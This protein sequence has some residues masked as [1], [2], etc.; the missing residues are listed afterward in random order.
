LDDPNALYAFVQGDAV[1]YIG[2][3]TRGVRKRFVT[4]RRP[5]KEQRTNLRCN[6][7][8][9]EALKAGAE[10]RILVFAPISHLRYLHFE[11]NLAAGL[12]DSLIT[13]FNPPWN[14]RERDKPITEEAEREQAEENTDQAADTIETSALVARP[15]SGPP[16]AS[17]KI[18]LGRAYFEQGLINPGVEAS[19]H[20]GADG[21][22]IQVLFDDGSDPVLSRINRRANPS[23]AVR[24]VGRNRQI[25]E[26]FQRHFRIGDVVGARVIDAN[27]ILLLAATGE[28]ANSARDA[29]AL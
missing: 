8:I 16:L 25:A 3:T 14:G 26:W 2:K 15:G 4:Y 10:I 7:K 22:H 27:R 9:K 6:A 5:G 29:D 20:L 19:V 13:A 24:V 11:I 1:R 18:K 23:G 28:P 17:F 21:E 12:E